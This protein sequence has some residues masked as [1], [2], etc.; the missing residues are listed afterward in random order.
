MISLVVGGGLARGPDKGQAA[1]SIGYLLAGAVDSVFSGRIVLPGCLCQQSSGVLQ[2]TGWQVA[3]S[4]W[5][6][7]GLCCLL[8]VSAAESKLNSRSR[9]DLLILG[10]DLNN[11]LTH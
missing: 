3:G 1:V 9:T 2:V 10:D 8:A 6:M 5:L 4:S 11:G 7:V